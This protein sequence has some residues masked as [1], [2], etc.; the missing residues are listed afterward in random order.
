LKQKDIE[1]ER[2]RERI[3]CD[4]AA[5]SVVVKGTIAFDEW[6]ISVVINGDAAIGGSSTAYITGYVPLSLIC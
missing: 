6:V 5:S 4:D 3:Q 2:E 1:R